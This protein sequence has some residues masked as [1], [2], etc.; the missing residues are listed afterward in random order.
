[1]AIWKEI[2]YV[3][4]KAII[5]LFPES[6]RE[7]NKDKDGSLP[8]HLACTC[9]YKI[10]VKLL[11]LLLAAYPEAARIKNRFDKFPVDY[12]LESDELFILW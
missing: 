5:D 2:S 6:V 8:L 11:S 12:A 3:V 9:S 10:S 1:M 4:I 7:K